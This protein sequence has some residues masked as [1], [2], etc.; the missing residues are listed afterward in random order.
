MSEE[1]YIKYGGMEFRAKANPR[2]INNFVENLPPEKKISMFTV[3]GELQEK[4]LIEIEPGSFS[5][6]DDEMIPFL[7]S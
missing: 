1:K 4:G 5:T 2:Q 6:I 7:E 3:V